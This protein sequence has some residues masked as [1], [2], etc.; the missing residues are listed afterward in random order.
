[1]IFYLSFF[2]SVLVYV[3]ISRYLWNKN[4]LSS[5]LFPLIITV[6]FAGLRGNVGTD[7]F[8]YKTFFNSLWNKS[9][10]TSQGLAFTFEPGFVLFSHCIKIIFDDDQFFLFSLACLYGFLFY[11]VLKK[12]KERD[13]FFLL[14]VSSYF[15]MFNL[16]LLRFGIAMMFLGLSYLSQGKKNK[17]LY[18]GLAISFHFSSIF[19]ILLYIKKEHIVKYIAG[20]IL[21]SILTFNYIQSKLGAYFLDF[22]MSGSF[23]IEMTIFLELIVFYFLIKWNSIKVMENNI[24]YCIILYFFFRWFGYLNDIISRVSFVLGFIIYLVLLRNSIDKKSRILFT[25][26]ILVYTYRSLS[27]LYN[28]DNSIDDL[29]FD[30][31]GMS[32]LYSQTKWLPYKFF[33]E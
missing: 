14:Y 15:V 4:S 19:A 5:L 21:F 28:S 25:F 12:I 2:L 20:V 23:R 10:I 6:L 31:N 32:S 9:E 3:I 7:T 29:L 8:A 24:L 22:F 33:W 16:N 18:F 27:F 13:L 11:R 30:Y 1:M 17:F 26:L